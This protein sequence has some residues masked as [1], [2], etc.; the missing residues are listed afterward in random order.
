MF[1]RV[2]G[3]LV[4]IKK[5]VEILENEEMRSIRTVGGSG[6]QFREIDKGANFGEPNK[7]IAR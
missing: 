1:F 4:G 6:N 3:D 5:H 7:E 2:S